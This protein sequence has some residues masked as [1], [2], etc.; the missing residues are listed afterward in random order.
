MPFGTTKGSDLHIWQNVDKWRNGWMLVRDN[1]S[2]TG[3]WRAAGSDGVTV[4]KWQE[5]CREVATKA[6][7]RE[8][9]ELG[10]CWKYKLVD[11]QGSKRSHTSGYC[12]STEKPVID[13]VQS[14][15]I[16]DRYTRGRRLGLGSKVLTIA[17][18]L[19]HADDFRQ[20]H[21]G[22]LHAT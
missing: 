2:Q 17:S 19:L 6:C 9:P 10:L 1:F 4:G 7:R 8:V 22:T 20:F 11:R 14:R 16:P 21:V 12:L 3:R 5:T 13:Q 18:P 15:W